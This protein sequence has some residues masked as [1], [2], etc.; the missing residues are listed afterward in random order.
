M[1]ITDDFR[2]VGRRR[3]TCVLGNCGR[4]HRQNIHWGEGSTALQW[5]RASDAIR[6][7][8]IKEAHHHSTQKFK[9]GKTLIT[10]SH[11]NKG[12]GNSMCLS[13][14]QVGKILPPYWQDFAT[15]L[16][17]VCQKHGNGLAKL[18]SSRQWVNITIKIVSSHQFTSKRHQ[19]AC[20]SDINAVS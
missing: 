4:I 20:E 3:D 16:A 14:R 13:C 8:R 10:L 15:A 7:N 9:K 18:L 1:V 6:Q 12:I 17:K 2:L 19:I 5:R 11:Y